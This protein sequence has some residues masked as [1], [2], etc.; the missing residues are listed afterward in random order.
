MNKLE[1]LSA[2]VRTT[3]QADYF[4]HVIQLPAVLDFQNRKKI[5][6]VTVDIKK[7]I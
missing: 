1:L 4:A 2:S 7:N 3:I 6:T 5:S